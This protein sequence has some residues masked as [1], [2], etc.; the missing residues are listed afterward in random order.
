MVLEDLQ[1]FRNAINSS[2]PSP[3]NLDLSGDLSLDYDQ[4]T[5][6]FALSYHLGKQPV[7]YIPNE[8]NYSASFPIFWFEPI[9]GVRLND[10]YTGIEADISYGF[11]GEVL[12]A[13]GSF[14]ESFVAKRT[15]FEPMVG[16]KIGLQVSPP[17]T[18]WLRGDVSGFDLAGETNF[19][20]NFI[21]GMDW[22]VS[23]STSILLA[24]RFYEF[25]YGNGQNLLDINFNGP[26]I[27]ITYNF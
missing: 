10:F 18:L 27:G 15:W 26:L 7:P 13:S 9:A 12:N 1:E 20:W 17:I 16:A 4:G 23:P 5:Y 8:T 11:D 14:R 3:D 22:W 19:S 24:Y 21:S 6:D 25:S 2:D